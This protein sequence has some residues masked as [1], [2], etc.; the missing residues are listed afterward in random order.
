MS[1]M[2]EFDDRAAK[3]VEAMY[4]T[5]DVVMQRSHVMAAMGLRP[6]MHALDIG[7]GPGLLAYDM[8]KAVTKT[9][10][11]TGIDMSRPMV[12]M[13]AGRCADMPW[14]TFEHGEAEQIPL[15]NDSV[16]VAVSTQVYEY[17]SDMGAALHEAK[18]VLKPGGRLVVLDTDWD[19]IVWH[20]S[21]RE[22]MERVLK[23]WDAHLADPH[24]PRKLPHMLDTAG[25]TVTRRELIPM[26]NPDWNPHSYSAGIMKGIQGFV[27]GRDG[28]SEDEARAW[29]DDLRQL[30]EDGRY[31]FS[32][33]RYLFVAVAG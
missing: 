27:S 20:S 3:A 32:L 1:D 31:F 2:I 24:L 16:D 28:I 33:N 6:G 23:A 12:E 25:F 5:P 8:G 26:F 21:N 17:V 22:R 30:G 19:S 13:S 4:L 7:V 14:C 29:A 18:R 9:G 11:V 15:A 10:K